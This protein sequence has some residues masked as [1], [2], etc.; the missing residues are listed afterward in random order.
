MA[1]GEQV[2]IGM[3][4]KHPESIILASPRLRCVLFC[5]VPDANGLVLRITDDQVTFGMKYYTR[6]IVGVTAHGIHFPG[7]GI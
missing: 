6:H 4:G 5:H 3:G 2:Q 1:S 7:L